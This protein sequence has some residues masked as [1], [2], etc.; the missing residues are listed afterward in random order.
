[1]SAPVPA[2]ASPP[3][4][5]PVD[6]RQLSL[7]RFAETA[8]ALGGVWPAADLVRLGADAPPAG[9]AEVHWSAQGERRAVAGDSPQT[10][11]HVQAHTEVEL[12]C[13][14]CLGPMTLVLDAQR[15]FRFVRDEEEATRLDEESED[16]V[17][18]LPKRGLLDLH[19][20]VED[21]LILALPL[22]P[23]HDVCPEPLPLPANVP[24]EEEVAPPNPFQAL[25]VLKRK[26]N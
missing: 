25:A 8:G 3:A 9:A 14:R 2:P 7:L 13:Q 22:V 12:V 23:R 17:L 16:D 11:L 18:A 24:D 15:S 19:E 21:E 4:S 26:P 10:W 20:L 6:P 5:R 1:M